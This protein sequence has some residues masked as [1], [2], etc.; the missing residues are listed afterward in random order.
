MG[1]YGANAITLCSMPSAK[2]KVMAHFRFMDLDIWKDSIDINRPGFAQPE[3]NQ[4]QK[5]SFKR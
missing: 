1:N 3:N 4:F 2:I 5:N